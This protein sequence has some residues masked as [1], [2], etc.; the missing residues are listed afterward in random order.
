MKVLSF[1]LLTA[2]I[3]MTLATG[4][5]A[6]A[7]KLQC[8]ENGTG[9]DNGYQIII[10]ANQDKATVEEQTIAGPRV[11]QEMPC[12]RVTPQKP[13]CCDRETLILTCFDRNAGEVNF[14]IQVIT[15]GLAQR[16]RAELLVMSDVGTHNGTEKVADLSCAGQ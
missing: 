16:T 15:G 3:L 13:E 5:V 6:G 2:S 7:G 11:L 4:A 8:K 1:L 10:S 9:P 12:L 14:Q